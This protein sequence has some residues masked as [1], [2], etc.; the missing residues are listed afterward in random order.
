M[1][2]DPSKPSENTPLDAVEMRGQLNG[3]KDLIDAKVESVTG[4]VVDS[5]DPANP[6]IRTDQVGG[7]PQLIFGGGIKAGATNYFLGANV[8]LSSNPGAAGAVTDG[9]TDNTGYQVGFAGGGTSF[10]FD[11]VTPRAISALRFRT[12]SNG[13]SNTERPM[14]LA[15]SD[16]GTDWTSNP[17]PNLPTFA[18]YQDVDIVFGNVGAHRYWRLLWTGGA[19]TRFGE[20]EGYEDRTGAIPLAELSAEAARADAA[21]ASE[22]AR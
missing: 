16:N 14:D 10:V 11:L 18:T 6:A 7:T 8:S 5:T 17:G 2:F 21:I 4:G 20:I 9:D 3:L 19:S 15:Y 1:P 22:V 13:G 12:G